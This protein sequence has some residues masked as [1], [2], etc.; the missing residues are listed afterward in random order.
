MKQGLAGRIA[1]LVGLCLTSAAR[2]VRASEATASARSERSTPLAVTVTDT[3]Q[4]NTSAHGPELVLRGTL[5]PLPTGQFGV[6]VKGA[7]DS[8]LFPSVDG[9]PGLVEGD[10]FR[11]QLPLGPAAVNATLLVQD[12][13]GVLATVS[14]PVP[15]APEKS[16][17]T[18][19]FRVNH[20]AGLAPLTTGFAYSGAGRGTHARLDADGD[21]TV[22]ADETTL[23]TFQFT[24]R[25]PGLYLP[26]LTVTDANGKISTIVSVVHVTDRAATDAR[27]LP[28]WQGVKAALRAGDVAA[29]CRFIHSEKRDAYETVWK[30]LPAAKLTNVDQI[31]TQIKLVEVGPGG[32]EYEMLREEHGQTFSYS[33]WFQLDR[34]GLWR[35]RSF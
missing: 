30:Q 2:P 28:V 5:R 6:T 15:V 1:V 23:S 13:S 26:R 8:T 22:D 17:P 11:A 27:I 32:A 7:H 24:Y 33:V 12:F 29:A 10:R 25:H 4:Q 16:S 14:I 21:G 9:T 20:P 35:L 18:E 34:D 31:M 19:A 3:V